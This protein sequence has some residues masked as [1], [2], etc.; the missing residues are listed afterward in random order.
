MPDEHRVVGRARPSRGPSAGARGRRRRRRRRALNQCRTARAG[1]QRPRV[2]RDDDPHVHAALAPPSTRPRRIPRSARYGLIDV[3]AALG[4]RDRRAERR[5]DRQVALARVVEQDLDAR[6]RRRPASP[7]R[8]GRGRP[9]APAAGRP[10][11]ATTAGTPPGAGRRSG[12]RAGPSRR[13]TSR[14][15]SGPRCR[16]RRRSATRPSTT[17]TLRWSKWRRSSNRQSIRR[18]PSSP[19][20][21][22]NAPW[23]ATTW[24]PPSV[25]RLVE[26]LRPAAR[27]GC[28]PPR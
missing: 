6:G 19:S 9:A 18:W 28:S 22:R 13:G 4:A 2:G 14:P 12:P 16:G 15:R 20:R 11:S 26:R 21:S 10:G 5:R 7:G 23:L 24:T 8:T 3:Q 25:E 1:G 17:T 27:A